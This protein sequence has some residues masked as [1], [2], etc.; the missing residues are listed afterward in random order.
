MAE[1]LDGKTLAKEIRINLKKEVEILKEKN[2]VP[3][4]AVIMVGDNDASKV[5]VKNKS[6]A[7][8][9]IGIKFEEYL[10]SKD[11]T[12]EEL[13]NLI[14]KLNVDKDTNGILLQSPIPNQL[15]IQEAFNTISPEKDVDG[16]NSYNVG[17]LCIGQEGFIPCTPLGIMRILEKYK[18]EMDGKKVAI[19]GRSNIVGKPM[20]RSEE[21]RVGKEC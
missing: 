3:H 4:F 2:I 14:K 18:I 13:I 6:K 9:E 10:L 11:T 12:Q 1:I 7:C 17:N 20:A 15:N 8:D 19:I 5:Y 21:R 16:F